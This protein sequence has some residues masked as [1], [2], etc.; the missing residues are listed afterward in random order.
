M[1]GNNKWYLV[2][3]RHHTSDY[4]DTLE[5]AEAWAK[6]LC[7]GYIDGT[8]SASDPGPVIIEC[9][10]MRRYAVDNQAISVTHL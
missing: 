6:R 10:R 9:R 2:N 3:T 1:T 4:F 7:N 8:I 5:A